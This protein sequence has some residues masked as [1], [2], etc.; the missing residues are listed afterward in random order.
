MIASAQAAGVTVELD[1]YPLHSQVFTGGA[2]CAPSPNPVACGNTAELQQFA[3]WVATIAETFPTVHQFVVMN[4]CNQPLFVNPQWNT[5]GQN[6]SAAI[7]GRALAAAYDALKGVSGSN[8]VW[9]VGPLAARQ[10]QAERA[11]QLVDLAG[12]V[13]AGARRVVQGVRH[14]DAPDGAAD[15]RARLPSV[16]GAAVAAVRDGLSRPARRERL[17]PPRIYQAFYDGFNGSPQRTIGQQKGGGLPVSLNEMGIQTDAV[18]KLGYTGIEVSANAAGGVVGQTATRGL[19]GELLPADARSSSRATRTCASSTSSTSST[20][21]T[22]PAGRAGSTGREPTPVPKQS[23]A[24]VRSWIGDDRRELP[25]K[26]R[27]LDAYTRRD[28]GQEIAA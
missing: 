2:R 7:C 16:P 17:E 25:G 11:E 15:G 13:P 21:R 14:R 22:W 20:S 18:G 8:F 24:V 1:L 12:H 27:S 10:R 23:A 5:A 9:G 3:A 28:G 26:A 19:P 4:E 6:Q